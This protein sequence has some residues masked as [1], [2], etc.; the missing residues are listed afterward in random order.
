MSQ[1][2]VETVI[3]PSARDLGGFG[4][5]RALPSSARQMVGPFIFLDELGPAD[6]A[7]GTGI[8]VR[9]H[10]H[11]GLATLTYLLEGELFHRDSLRSAQKI[12]PGAINLMIAGRG[13]VHSERSPGDFRATGG[14]MRGLQCWLA[15]PLSA[16]E[17]D[18][19]FD[20]YER[21]QLPVIEGDGFSLRLAIGGLHGARAP[22]KSFSP[23]F[24][25][26]VEILPGAVYELPGEYEDRGL[27]LIE[28]VVEI[29]GFPFEP[30]RLVLLRPG[31][32]IAL[33]AIGGKAR[34]VALG[35]DILG[36]PRHLWWNFVSSSRERIRAAR[37]DWDSG[38]FSGIEGDPEFIP[39][40]ELTAL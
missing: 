3:I 34:L 14:R 15:L 40:P 25:A 10:P 4:V 35:G 23:S 38:K 24:L 19:G 33:R 27:Y 6:F 22:V 26:D 28:G 1:P 20:H 13:I 32:K 12:T 39:A 17:T 8:D 36:E 30:G 31:E 16:E 7:A 9:P 2:S 29:D 11:I 5:R 21:S 18:P 37:A